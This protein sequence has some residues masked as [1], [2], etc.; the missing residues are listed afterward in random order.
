[1]SD[2]DTPRLLSAIE[3]VLREKGYQQSEDADL[4][5]NIFSETYEEAAPGSSVGVGLGGTGGDVGGGVSVGI[6]I[7]SSGLKQQ[8]VFDLI[9]T[10]RDQLIWQAISTDGFRENMPPQKRGERLRAIAY[11]VFSG[12]PPQK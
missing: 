8:I 3:D 7:S 10:G 12:F 1:M 6:P 5:L 11:K 4:L 2:L 9:D